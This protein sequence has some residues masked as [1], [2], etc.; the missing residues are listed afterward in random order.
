METARRALI[1]ASPAV[2]RPS[3]SSATSAKRPLSQSLRVGVHVL[4]LIA[5]YSSSSGSS[6]SRLLP[7]KSNRLQFAAHERGQTN[8]I[9]NEIDERYSAG[10]EVWT[11]L[12]PLIGGPEWLRLHRAVWIR[13]AK[14]E[15]CTVHDFIPTKTEPRDVVPMLA[16]RPVPGRLRDIEFRSTSLLGP[17]YRCPPPNGEL[18]C[19]VQNQD[20]ANAAISAVQSRW[21]SD[22]AL[23]SND[24]SSYTAALVAALCDG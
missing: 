17:S 3:L 5:G 12:H 20:V 8:P 21:N 13:D 9:E 23:L 24:C 6:T 14:S 18:H 19:R 11:G 16:L 22:I 1:R 7:R 15:T 4:Y 2:A 10:V